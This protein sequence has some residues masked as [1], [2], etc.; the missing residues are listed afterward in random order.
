MLMLESLLSDVISTFP[1]TL[2][3]RC[4]HF[5]LLSALRVINSTEVKRK[6]R[7]RKMGG[8]VQK[9]VFFFF[10]LIY[11]LVHWEVNTN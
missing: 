3:E 7:Q 5:L 1:C 11:L 10:F 4:M 9:Y 6:E 2:G 8:S